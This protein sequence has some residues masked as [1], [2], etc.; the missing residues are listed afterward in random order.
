MTRIVD[1]ASVGADPM[2]GMMITMNRHRH[3]PEQSVRKLREGERLLSES[4]D[5]TEVFRSCATYRFWR[6][7]PRLRKTVWL[8]SR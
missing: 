7:R 6:S 3:T 1:Q 4:K 8:L 5:L 2:D